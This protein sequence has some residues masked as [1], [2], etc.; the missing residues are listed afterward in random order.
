MSRRPRAGEAA[1][2]VTI[3]ATAAERELWQ[4]AADAA[5]AASLSDAVRPAITRWA[6]GVVELKLPRGAKKSRL[7]SA[8][9]ESDVHTRSKP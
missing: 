5:G 3:R 6:T 7:L 1:G 9:R 4:T 2:K 8:A